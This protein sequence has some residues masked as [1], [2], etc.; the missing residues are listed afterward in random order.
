MFGSETL[1]APGPDEFNFLFYQHFFNLVKHD[2]LL[3]LSHF[4]THSLNMAELNHAMV[5]LI[6]KEKEVRSI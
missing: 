6:P 4:Y 1:G 3:I 2:L 5:C